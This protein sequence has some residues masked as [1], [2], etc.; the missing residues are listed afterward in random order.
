MFF[1]TYLKRKKERKKNS[2][3]EINDNFLSQINPNSERQ[4]FKQLVC[5]S[6]IGKRVFWGNAGCCFSQT[7][8]L[9]FRKDTYCWKT[10]YFVTGA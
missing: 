10:Q 6:K 2:N 1:V 7:G 5:P 4:D 3:R 9:G 8:V